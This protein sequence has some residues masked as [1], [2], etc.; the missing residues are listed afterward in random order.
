MD[1][2][3]DIIV[4]KFRTPTTKHFFQWEKCEIFEGESL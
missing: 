3:K 4:N 2:H 1:S